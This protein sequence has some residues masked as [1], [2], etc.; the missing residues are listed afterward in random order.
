MESWQIDLAEKNKERIESGFWNYTI[1]ACL[2][3]NLTT[4]SFLDER[5][6]YVNYILEVEDIKKK[7]DLNIFTRIKTNDQDLK[8]AI[9]HVHQGNDFYTNRVIANFNSMHIDHIVPS[10]R[11]G[12]D[13]IANYAPVINMT[14]RRKNDR[15]YRDITERLVFSN[16]LLYSEEVLWFYIIFKYN[17][18]HKKSVS[19]L[20]EKEV[21]IHETFINGYLEISHKS[22][23]SKEKQI[24]LKNRENNAIKARKIL[25]ESDM[26]NVNIDDIYNSKHDEEDF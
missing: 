11:G 17:L 7:Y 25:K 21:E 26:A 20:T 23:F 24:D 6:E 2:N 18:H 19:R 10:S 14:N 8:E 15:Y 12:L 9:Y 4:A 1:E 5:R 22:N 3:N 16:I 13:C